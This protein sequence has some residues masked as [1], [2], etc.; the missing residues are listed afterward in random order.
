MEENGLKK[1]RI[2]VLI[3]P[4]TYDQLQRIRKEMHVS[5]SQIVEAALENEFLKLKTKKEVVENA[6]A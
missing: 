1:R 6:N 5:M 4:Q 3:L 2:D